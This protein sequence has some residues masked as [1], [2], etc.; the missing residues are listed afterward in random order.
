MQRHFREMMLA[1]AIFVVGCG[2]VWGQRLEFEVASVKPNRAL[3]VVDATV[4]RSGEREFVRNVEPYTLIFYAYHLIGNYQ[5]AGYTTPP[6]DW[7]WYDV[8]ARTGSAAATEDDVRRMMQT[9]LAD[10]FRLRVHWEEREMA[11]WELV[12]EKGKPKLTAAVSESRT[13]DGDCSV[14]AERDGDYLICH[15]VALTSIADTLGAVLH[16]P[17]ANQT[18]INGLYDFKLRYFPESRRTTESDLPDAPPLNSALSEQLGL[19]L[20]KSKVSVKVL[21][22]DHLERPSGN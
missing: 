19:A 11:G 1:G 14:R 15:A 4:H 20:R 12:I 10:R 22:I 18:R 17:V 6:E 5:I 16:A 21:V 9:L 2:G 3:D 13:N 8:E 7:R